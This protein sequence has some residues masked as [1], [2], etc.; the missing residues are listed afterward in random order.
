MRVR[1][2]GL[3]MIVCKQSS[4][5]SVTHNL[6]SIEQINMVS[7]GG[8]VIRVPTPDGGSALITVY[9]PPFRRKRRREG[10]GNVA[11]L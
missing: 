9:H 4:G 7:F 10:T 11:L 5:I 2:N 1:K 8:S 6:S 3:K